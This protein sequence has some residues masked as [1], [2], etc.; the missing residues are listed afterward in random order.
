MQY[1]LIFILGIAA[2]VY[3]WPNGK[4]TVQEPVKQTQTTP[5]QKVDQI[6]N[7]IKE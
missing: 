3:F 6:L 7:I 5:G 1:V 2:G 4:V